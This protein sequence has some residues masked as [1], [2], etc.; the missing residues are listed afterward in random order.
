MSNFPNIIIENEDSERNIVE[1]KNLPDKTTDINVSNNFKIR[2]SDSDSDGTASIKSDKMKFKPQKTQVSKNFDFGL[3]ADP[4]RTKQSVQESQDSESEYES[5]EN[6]ESESEEN[7][8]ENSNDDKSQ[9]GFSRDSVVRKSTNKYKNLTSSQLKIKKK[10]LLLKLHDAEQNGYQITGKYNMNSDIEDLEAEYDLYEKRMEQT[11]MVDFLQD[12]L[13]FIIKGIE[14]FNGFYK[15]MGVNLTGLSDKIYDRREQLE[16]VIKRLAIKY[17]GGTEM[18]PELSLLFIIGGAMIMTHISNTMLKSGGIDKIL[19]NV[20]NPSSSSDNN[21]MGNIMSMFGNLMKTSQNSQTSNSQTSNSQSTSQ[22]ELKPPQF[23]LNSI[24][25]KM[26]DI[27][28]TEKTKPVEKNSL[29]FKTMGVP[30]PP[31]P[32]KIS[33]NGN[34]DIKERFDKYRKNYTSKSSR[35]SVS[36]DISSDDDT[37]QTMNIT[38]PSKSTTDKSKKKRNTIIL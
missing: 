5:E 13:M 37:V 16:H 19:N 15:P 9:G 34:N 36:S 8:E 12:G 14:M 27:S 18:P 25:S 20:I 38:I 3:Y 22:P 21:P 11:A 4:R 31:P 24:L 7:S 17:T 2:K 29:P 10:E 1:V 26:Q 30:V 32:P 28:P 33:N 23:D 6:S 35:F